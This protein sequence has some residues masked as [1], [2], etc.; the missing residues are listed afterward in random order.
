MLYDPCKHDKKI[1]EHIE[2]TSD[3]NI[4][5]IRCNQCLKKLLRTQH[6]DKFIKFK[7]DY[8]GVIVKSDELEKT[9][10][11]IEYEDVLIEKGKHSCTV[12]FVEQADEY[13]ILLVDGIKDTHYLRKDIRKIYE[14]YN[15]L[16]KKKDRKD[17]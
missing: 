2:R 7:E 16:C 4:Y 12:K 6:H 11:E 17:L 9:P 10:Y 15:M 1:I 5:I 3:K 14:K 13:G 8:N